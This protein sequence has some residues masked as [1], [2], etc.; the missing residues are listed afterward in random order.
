MKIQL[1]G[2]ETDESALRVGLVVR[3]DICDGYFVIG[4]ELTLVRT[5]PP[6]GSI[7]CTIGIACLN[8]KSESLENIKRILDFR[9]E[10][11]RNSE[12]LS[13]EERA[14]IFSEID[15]PEGLRRLA[16]ERL[17]GLKIE[18]SSQGALSG[19]L[20]GYALADDIDR[21]AAQDQR[22]KGQAGYVYLL[23]SPEGYCKIG[24]TKNL[25]PRLLAIGL[26]LPFRVEL[27]HSIAVSDPV[28]A[29]R[30]LHKKFSACRMNGEWF[31]LS[32]ADINWIKS[33]NSLEPQ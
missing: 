33:L 22:K 27:V 28:W 20:S 10:D 19:M 16:S 11:A 3:C 8:C 25:T 15:N 4:K 26:Q 12:R 18:E 6:S 30:F 21:S 23:C 29:E 1:I 32:D 2:I 9:A 5:Y 17:C 31:L 14:E 13:S 7:D 24:R